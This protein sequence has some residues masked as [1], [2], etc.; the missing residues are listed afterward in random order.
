MYTKYHILQLPPYLKEKYIIIC[1]DTNTSP[2]LDFDILLHCNKHLTKVFF[3]VIEINDEKCFI[4]YSYKNIFFKVLNIPSKPGNNIFDN[5]NL[6]ATPNF[7]FEIVPQVIKKTFTAFYFD[8]FETQCI[9]KFS[10]TYLVSSEC[11]KIHC[12]PILFSQKKIKE[13]KFFADLNRRMN[14]FSEKYDYTF[15]FDKKDITALE[16]SISIKRIQYNQNKTS[17]VFKN[18]SV[19]DFLRALFLDESKYNNKCR[20]LLTTME[21]DQKIIACH[22]G[23]LYKNRLHYWFPAYISDYKNY[24]VGNFLLLNLIEN[25]TNLEISEIDQSIGLGISKEKFSTQIYNLHKFFIIKDGI[26][27]YFV[28]FL[29]KFFWKIKLL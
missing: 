13:K 9:D 14:R 7:N 20:L 16:E 10:P 15:T 25:S 29:I 3:L 24:G 18:S 11:T 1:Q 12:D 4:P 26:T 22:F 27:S 28:K 8:H 17:D 6:I 19:V 23:L 2:F 5:Y 21:F